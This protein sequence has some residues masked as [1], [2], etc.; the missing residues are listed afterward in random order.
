M[1]NAKRKIRNL[2]LIAFG[3]LLAALFFGCTT[4]NAAEPTEVCCCP[5]P[6]TLVLQYGVDTYT[7]MTDKFVSE[8]NPST[9]YESETEI[10]VYNHMTNGEYRAYIYFDLSLI[11]Q[12]AYVE[13][14]T[15]ELVRAQGTSNIPLFDIY[16]NTESWPVPLYWSNK[17]TA[18]YHS[19]V[20]I[21]SSNVSIPLNTTM[22]QDWVT[23]PNN[24]FGLMFIEPDS[25]DD[26]DVLTFYSSEAATEAN[27]PKLTIVYQP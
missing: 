25:P 1:R 17:P 18:Y 2:L 13:S 23:N 15:L 14:A 9:Q 21:L 6:V 22:V 12:T 10:N 24:N 3:L 11:P 16:R 19:Y 8:N 27:R 4:Q 20:D 5:T 26:T 7:A